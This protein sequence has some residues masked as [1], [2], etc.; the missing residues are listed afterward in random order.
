M[1]M[2]NVRTLL[3]LVNVIPLLLS[4]P[5]VHPYFI[6][7]VKLNK[8]NGEPFVNATSVTM[9]EVIDCPCLS[10]ITHGMSPDLLVSI[11]S[12]FPTVILPGILFILIIP[13]S[14]GV[15]CTVAAVSPIQML[16]C[17]NIS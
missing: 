8:L 16:G 9:P 2:S 14:Y 7:L 17:N 13:S 3:S 4:P 6:I 5:R 15:I 1:G 10:Q 12:P 11:M